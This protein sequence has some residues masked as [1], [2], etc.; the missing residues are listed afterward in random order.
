[1]TLRTNAFDLWVFRRDPDQPRY[2]IF[3]TT[4]NCAPRTV[5][6]CQT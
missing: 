6:R 3:H 1:M 2:L 4:P 5:P